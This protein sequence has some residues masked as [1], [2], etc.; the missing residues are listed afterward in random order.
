VAEADPLLD[1]IDADDLSPLGGRP[2]F[3]FDLDRRFS[4]GQAERLAE[5]TQAILVGVDRSGALPALEDRHFDLLLTTQEC[6]PA[7]WVTVP[8]TA[9]DDTLG[10]LSRAIAATPLAASILCRTL[11]VG[12]QLDFFDA[13]SIESLAYSTLLGGAEFRRWRATAR[14]PSHAE[15]GGPLVDYHRS[16]ALVRL[17][18]NRPASRNATTAAMRDALC[19][20]LRSLLD[21]P[22]RPELLLSGSGH[23]FSVGG[24]L[25]E[26]GTSDDLAQAHAIRTLRSPAA[27]IHRLGKR[28]EVSLHG[29]VIG[30]GLE[31]AAAAGVRK[32]AA[33]VFF[34][35]PELAMGLIPGAGGTATISRAIGRHRTAFLALTGRRIGAVRALDWGLIHEI[36]P[37]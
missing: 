25:G 34:Q 7:P 10:R 36:A 30:A 22:T 13:L 4:I 5:R 16:G 6:A 9:F 23:C 32:A 24:H 35:L 31:I 33:R 21:D 2:L 3:L 28:A 19:D 11:R 14:R 17:I 37:E 8:E 1:W 26:F 12:E 29:A 18:L 20:A 27:L 15:Q